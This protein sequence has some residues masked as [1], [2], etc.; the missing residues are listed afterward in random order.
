MMVAPRKLLAATAFAALTAAGA[1]VAAVD[2]VTISL[3]ELNDLHA[4]L[5]G[6]KDLVRNPDGT[7]RVE[8]RGGMAR[9]KTLIDRVRSE[10]PHTAVMN[11]GD[12][13]HGGVEA[14]FSL[15]NAV[16][17]PLNALGID[18]GVAGNWD[19]Y[20]TPGVTRARYGRIDEDI[21][22]AQAWIDGLADPIPVKR[23]NFPN[24]GANVKDITDPLPRDFFPPTHM[25]QFDG[26]KVGF[27]GF[28]SD[29]VE[30]M[31]PLLA[32]GM[33]FAYG[34]EE[35]KQ[36]LIRHAQDLRERGADV[37]VVMSELGM[38]KDISLSKA[39][40][41][42]T[43]AGTLPP[44]LIDM[45]F[46]G[47]THDLTLT[48]IVTATDGTPLYAPVVQA[49][50]DAYLGRWDVTLRHAGTT[51]SG[52]FLRRTTEHH[53]TIQRTA[54]RILDVD[55]SVPEDAAVKRMIEDAR[56]P[57]LDKDVHLSAVPFFMQKLTQPIDTVV[58]RLQPGS[59]LNQNAA[60]TGVLS[61]KT[62]LSSTFN[63]ALTAFM[64][65]ITHTQTAISPGFRMGT[66]VPEAGFLLE[67]GA[68]ASG[69][70]T[71]ED[72]FRFFPMYYGL[73]VGSTTGAH[74]KDVIEESLKRVYSSDAWNTQ[75]GTNYGYAGLNIVVDLAAGDGRRLQ[76]LRHADGRPVDDDE[77]IT[78]A[79][80]RRLPIDFQGNLCGMPGFDAVQDVRNPA[81]GLPWSLADVFVTML[82]EQGYPFGTTGTSI[83][84]V[85]GT[86]AWPESEYLQ[87]IEGV[88]P[89]E[90]HDP[91]D[92]CGYFKWNCVNN[93]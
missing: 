20:F 31:Q 25:L 8:M 50:D 91:T 17:D 85:S 21:E 10:N 32:E 59:V 89:N 48:P 60:L 84:D 39:L 46:S 58:G 76:A 53:W 27:I 57:F 93:E 2:E 83:V 12:T 81:T 9:I 90:P 75:G 11:I 66:T 41:A 78:V 14:F 67:N 49:G 72:V 36:L 44:G 16:S 54:W 77:I 28:T 22:V 3:I 79:G 30:M 4:N 73:A 63:D 42:M 62:A 71:L 38:Q 26:V 7:T 56:A 33:D 18:V 65:D 35:H 74:M 13:Y 5:I 34:L 92:P 19:Y 23:P 88:G 15:G 70:I 40:A 6:H 87:P 69:D 55:E 68:V 51:T 61:R 64:R 45:F 37:V 52:R 80:C 82:Q 86:A 43:A 24:L 1:A 29:I 47:H